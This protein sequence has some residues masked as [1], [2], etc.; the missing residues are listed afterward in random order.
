MFLIR[1]INENTQLGLLHLP[2]F[3]AFTGISAK[4][5][6]E[7]KA[8]VFLLQ[9]LFHKEVELSYNTEGKPELHQ[10]NCHI[11]ISHSHDKLVIICN[12]SAP[13]GID[14]ELIRDKVLKIQDKF[15]SDD[16]IRDAKNNVDKLIL[17]WG[18]KEAMYKLYSLKEI[19]FADHLF[20]HD[21]EL[22]NEGLLVGEIR[23]E[24][25]HKKLS[26]HYEKLEDYMLV[27][28]LEERA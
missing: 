22:K 21:F 23:L 14:I 5:E 28:V 25:F 20:V 11:S 12:R 17:Y 10:E 8:T 13:T 3:I 6:L 9:K 16:E 26:L 24:T 18:A 27:Y 1:K 7:K 2:D 4:R 19:V 15:L